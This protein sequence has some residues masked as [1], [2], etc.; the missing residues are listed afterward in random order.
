MYRS[1]HHQRPFYGHFFNGWDADIWAAN[2]SDVMSEDEFGAP[3]IAG[4]TGIQTYINTLGNDAYAGSVPR[5]WLEELYAQR[6]ET[7]E[8]TWIRYW[9]DFGTTAY[10][11]RTLTV[12]WRGWT[13][14]SA[15][16]IHTGDEAVANTVD[17]GRL[18]SWVETC[19]RTTLTITAEYE[20]LTKVTTIEFSDQVT[21]Q[22]QRTAG[23]DWLTDYLSNVAIDINP[24]P[25]AVYY[26][27][28]P[29]TFYWGN[30]EVP[31]EMWGVHCGL[32]ARSG[33]L[34]V[35]D[36][37]FV[38]AEWD[39]ETPDLFIGDANSMAQ[40][41]AINGV[42]NAAE[43]YA[44]PFVVPYPLD[45]KPVNIMAKG[46][47]YWTPTGLGCVYS[48]QSPKNLDITYATDGE[49]SV[50]PVHVCM[51]GLELPPGRN[52]VPPDFSGQ[53]GRTTY[54]VYAECCVP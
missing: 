16:T 17:P 51:P 35:V 18:L 9:D 40:E 45:D 8:Q 41:M 34:S 46:G 20:W 48:G 28:S 42:P 12:K 29:A 43:D 49:P 3:M 37:E 2:Q 25:L 32:Y 33:T 21:Y 14:T 7:I 15:D 23:V 50:V 10:T 38:L 26:L 30:V 22:E 6:L 44:G 5:Y 27:S 31:G 39:G 1:I 24:A 36:E 4:Q 53:V 47:H 11:D 52:H 19:T 54:F 13:H